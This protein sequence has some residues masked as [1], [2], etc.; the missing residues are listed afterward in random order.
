MKRA[1]MK[2]AT[3]KRPAVHPIADAAQ[4]AYPTRANNPH[5]CGDESRR[6]FLRQLAAAGALGWVGVPKLAQGQDMPANF[7]I[8]DRHPQVV[9]AVQADEDSDSDRAMAEE[10]EPEEAETGSADGQRSAMPPGS[11][12]TALCT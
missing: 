9:P 6:R 7:A 1:D 8:L 4:Q 2:P 12:K 5:T 3:I 10:A 11:R